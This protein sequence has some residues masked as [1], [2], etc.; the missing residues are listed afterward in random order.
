M[1]SSGSMSM[2]PPPPPPPPG[3][4]LNDLDGMS[5]AT[6]TRSRFAPSRI[7]AAPGS[8]ASGGSEDSHKS[9]EF[10]RA[11]QSFSSRSHQPEDT[12]DL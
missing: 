10:I 12:V 11:G 1:N 8:V 5:L 7:A 6:S 3:V 4:I 9:V 2:P